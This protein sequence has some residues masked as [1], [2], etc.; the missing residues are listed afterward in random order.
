V[1]RRRL[2]TELVRRGFVGSLEEAGQ[3]IAAGAVLVRGA[4]ATK[5]SSMIGED[6]AVEIRPHV[7]R[8]VSRG[9]EKLDAALD[10][11][12]IVVTDRTALD[13]GA[14]TGGFTDVL[15]RRG[16][17]H[18]TAV[19]VGYG[20]LAW[21]LRS[22][23][24]VTTLDRTNVR[25]LGVEDLP[26]RPQVVVADVSFISLTLVAPALAAVSAPVADHVYLV[27]PQFEAARDGVG[28]G[29]VVRDPDVWASTVRAVA[30]A[31]L[32]IGLAPRG[33]MPSP[34]RGPAGNVE[35]LL[36]T[37]LGWPDAPTARVDDQIARAVDEA[38]TLGG[39]A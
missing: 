31:A 21:S 36:W 38:R 5:A 3:E 33:V 26:H 12:G 4:P 20:Q 24:R 22:D 34:V 23:P 2:D 39:A 8:F 37:S 13:A 7:R 1:A 11:F 25:S 35:F 29:G 18:V 16:A 10:R 15:L 27:K 6:E 32:G 19:D 28:K 9:G 30:D 14:S 17:S